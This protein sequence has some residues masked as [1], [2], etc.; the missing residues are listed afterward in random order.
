MAQKDFVKTMVRLPPDV[1]AWLEARAIRNAGTMNS[2]VVQA[3]REKMD[4]E[5]AP[6]A[7]NGTEK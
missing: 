5:A 6:V 7:P 4:R 1:K 2:E 3:I